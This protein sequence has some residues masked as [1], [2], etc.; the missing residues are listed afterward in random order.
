MLST[1]LHLRTG[2]LDCKAIDLIL[3]MMARSIHQKIKYAMIV[4][5]SFFALTA[6]A[7]QELQYVSRI[8]GTEIG[9]EV[10]GKRNKIVTPTI[11][12]GELEN[13]LLNKAKQAYGND[14]FLKNFS[15]S[16]RDDG[17][18]LSS[19]NVVS[20]YLY[21]T[22]ADVYRYV[23][24]PDPVVAQPVSEPVK[25]TPKMDESLAIEKAINKAMEPISSGSRI[26]I[27]T[28]VTGDGLNR[29]QIKDI[30]LDALLESNYKVVAKEY[31]EKL[32]EEIEEQ[33]SGEYNNRTTV[34]TDNFSAVG[35]FIDVK[36]KNNVARVYLINV[37]TG[38]YAS[39]A[40]QVFN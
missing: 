22:S 16:K 7:R 28:I 30:I 36:I 9:D 20:Y 8:T 38:E 6:Y 25:E 11:P 10:K 19:G 40:N 37:S 1:L 23:D 21:S 12:A 39:T 13:R 26:A 34:K 18:E 29:D 15:F 3:K 24:I 27:N 14:V 4:L 33:Q 35:Y 32:K 5:C 17:F 31:L 2:R